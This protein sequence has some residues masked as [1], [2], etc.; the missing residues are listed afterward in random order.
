[1]VRLSTYDTNKVHPTSATAK[2]LF[3]STAQSPISSHH[4]QDPSHQTNG[5]YG[6]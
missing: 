4:L 2:S 5:Q 3:A 1:M 6:D